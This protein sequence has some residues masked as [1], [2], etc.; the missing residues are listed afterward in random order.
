MTQAEAMVFID[1]LGTS[2]DRD[3]LLEEQ[4]FKSCA[5][6]PWPNSITGSISNALAFS[7]ALL[8]PGPAST[9]MHSAIASSW[10]HARDPHKADWPQWLPR[11][12]VAQTLHVLTYSPI[13]SRPAP[14]GA[15]LANIDLDI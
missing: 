13:R 8:N 3:A 1:R 6:S 2:S 12:I 5:L 10:V 9:L 7:V 15:S 4:I 14:T 11:M